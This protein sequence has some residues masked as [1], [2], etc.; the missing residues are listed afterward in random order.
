[1]GFTPL[2]GEVKSDRDDRLAAVVAVTW[3]LEMDVGVFVTAAVEDVRLVIVLLLVLSIVIL[4]FVLL[5]FLLPPKVVLF[6]FSLSAVEICFLS[7]SSRLPSARGFAVVL[8]VV[9]MVH[10]RNNR[11]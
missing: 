2:R 1:M 7:T 4:L 9:M 3:A 8:L 11:E 6:W 10:N 5:S